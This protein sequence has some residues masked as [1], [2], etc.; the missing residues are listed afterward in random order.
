VDAIGYARVVPLEN[1]SSA[2]DHQKARIAEY[3]RQNNLTLAKTFEESV[4]AE[5]SLSGRTELLKA[6]AE[7]GPNA[8]LV[9]VRADRLGANRKILQEINEI[10]TSKEIAV[11]TVHGPIDLAKVKP[12]IEVTVSHQ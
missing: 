8:C 2:L 11:H 3:C 10:C 6:L 4:S 1:A 5:V 7:A 12:G 9:I